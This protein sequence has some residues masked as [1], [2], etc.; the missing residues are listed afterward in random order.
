MTWGTYVSTLRPG[1]LKR[2]HPLS[3][4]HLSLAVSLF[5]SGLGEDGWENLRQHR[6]TRRHAHPHSESH[7]TALA[8]QHTWHRIVLCSGRSSLS[9]CRRSAVCR[10][11][12]LLGPVG[13]DSGSFGRLLPITA[14]SSSSAAAVATARWLFCSGA[15]NS[16]SYN[17]TPGDG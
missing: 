8:E 14:R 6:K 2:R 12:S 11:S 10:A 1:K 16:E 17:S 15:G 9:K 5:R 4:A 3:L 7:S 13:R